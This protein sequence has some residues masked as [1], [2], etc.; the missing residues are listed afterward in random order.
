MEG[1]GRADCRRND[2]GESWPVIDKEEK[3][4]F[5]TDS[6]ILSRFG[7]PLHCLPLQLR[8]VHLLLLFNIL[9]YWAFLFFDRNSGF[10][11]TLCSFIE[12]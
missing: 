2:V 5:L 1:Q 4:A 10:L 12:P 11:T 8:L 3:L 6:K 7:A 9:T